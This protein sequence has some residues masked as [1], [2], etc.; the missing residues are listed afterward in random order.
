MLPLTGIA[1]DNTQDVSGSSEYKVIDGLGLLPEEIT[2][3]AQNND[4]VTREEYAVVLY[5]ILTYTDKI[6]ESE[7]SVWEEEF[8]GD[9]DM[10]TPGAAGAETLIF[11]DVDESVS[12]YSQINYVASS[13]FISAA[14]GNN[15]EPDSELDNE[16]ALNSLI[17]MLGY[18]EFAQLSGKSALMTANELG[19][20]SAGAENAVMSVEDLVRLLY[21]ALE[22]NVMN[23]NI[24]NSRVVY[25][26]TEESFMERWLKIR[27]IKGIL[28]DNGI[29]ALTG[30]S[31]VGIGN[32]KIADMI[33]TDQ[34]KEDVYDLLGYQTEAYYSFAD[35]SV[36]DVYVAVPTTK[37]TVTEFDILDMTDYS[38]YRFQYEYNGRVRSISLK[39]NTYMIYN[40][41]AIKS[42]DRETFDFDDGT[43]RI[44]E[45]G[46]DYS[47][48]AVE[49]Y[50]NWVVA[51]Y[52]TSTN[53]LYNKAK[54]KIDPNGDE[55]VDLT[56]A[57]ENGTLFMS[58]SDGTEASIEDIKENIAAD[59]IIN[60]NYVKMILTDNTVSDFTVTSIDGNTSY[61]IYYGISNGEEEYNVAKRYD[62]L[63]GACVIGLNKSYTLILNREGVAVWI[64]PVSLKYDA[65]GYLVSTLRD[66]DNI[67]TI[68]KIFTEAGRMVKL[69]TADKVTYL[70]E[71]GNRYKITA[72]KL[73]VRLYDY[74]GLITYKTD[75]NE[76]VTYVEIP[77]ADA[78]NDSTLQK[79]HDGT[80]MTYK[81]AGRYGMFGRLI[82]ITSDTKIFKVPESE[83]GKSDNANYAILNKDSAFATDSKY[84]IVG[85]AQKSD[86][87]VASYV[88]FKNDAA[89][90]WRYSPEDLNFLL[91]DEI[92]MGLNEDDEPCDI[93]TGWKFGY[94]TSAEQ[95]TMYSEYSK[96]DDN[97]NSVSALSVAN[98]TPKSKDE[99]GNMKKYQIQK[100][101]IIR[102]LTDGNG[103][104]I[105]DAE[106]FYR[107]DGENPAF[108]GGRSGFLA[109]SIGYY[110]SDNTFSNPYAICYYGD[111]IGMT[112][113]TSLTH[114]SDKFIGYTSAYYGFVYN[115]TDGIY[116]CTTNDLSANTGSYDPESDKYLTFYYNLMDTTIQIDVDNGVLSLVSTRN[117][118]IKTYKDTGNE[119]S[120]IIRLSV[121]GNDRLTII[122]NGE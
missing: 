102:Y 42:W 91:V 59:I 48:V 36:N 93:I 119:C 53:T 86:T 22:L 89:S 106:L 114:D 101:D 28:S 63:D 24:V 12:H 47:V 45:N 25:S 66:D 98:D 90:E 122:I 70:D 7:S 71:S 51:S 75:E 2:D 84:S 10:Q 108:E 105:T 85:Y 104:N 65:V 54:D 58:W 76:A 103:D 13:G 11:G 9:Y 112:M 21:S 92:T 117:P 118:N 16:T 39:T 60:G 40:G 8:F 5:N 19:L 95:V 64:E 99:S 44:I 109:G 111:N 61:D 74:E 83:S 62:D 81:N 55:Y 14:E 87:R 67:S 41:K 6:K 116:E 29:T 33:L 37:N 1:S 27:K 110:Q 35:N 4:T 50:A 97:G 56:D 88:V 72:D 31:E 38:N 113:N 107:M 20:Y 115:E 23:I 69:N 15:F 34:C 80:E 46:E 120:R 77:R 78:V 96:T 52:S 43:V 73:Y 3:K 49:S 121:D 26:E 68:L 30:E 79:I 82:F 32:I 94:T 57:I 17:N 18:S 100:G